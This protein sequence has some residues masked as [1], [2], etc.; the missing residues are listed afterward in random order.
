M[1]ADPEHGVEIAVTDPGPGFDPDA[2]GD[3]TDPEAIFNPSG[4]GIVV[5]RWHVDELVYEDGGRKA[6]LRVRPAA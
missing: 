5:A 1:V 6:I 4:R 2:L 3:T